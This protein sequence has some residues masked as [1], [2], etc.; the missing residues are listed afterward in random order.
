MGGPSPFLGWNLQPGPPLPV[1]M[2]LHHHSH[3]PSHSSII[4]YD[5]CCNVRD[6]F[7]LFCTFSQLCL[8]HE[9]AVQGPGLG[10]FLQR[11][12]QQ[13]KVAPD[14]KGRMRDTWAFTIWH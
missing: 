9:N 6:C 2:A 3:I 13:V 10:C 5:T 1:P 4:F 7:C 12:C 8:L 14:T 11:A